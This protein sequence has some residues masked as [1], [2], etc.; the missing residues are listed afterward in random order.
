MKKTSFK[1][2][3]NINK[4]ECTACKACVLACS[5]HHSRQFNYSSSCIS[6]FKNNEDGDIE[7]NIDHNR[8][9]MCPEEDT[10]LCMAFCAVKAIH[11]ARVKV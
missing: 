1:Y 4:H 8:C 5:F 2:L 6:I 10:P 3:I 9:D 11:F 7:I